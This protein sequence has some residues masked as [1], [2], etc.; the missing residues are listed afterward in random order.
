MIS[1]KTKALALIFLGSIFASLIINNN[2]NFN[3][4]EN[5][6]DLKI[7]DEYNLKNAFGDWDAP[8]KKSVGDNPINLF[9]G[10]A[11][12]DGYNDIVSTNFLSDDITIILWNPVSGN[13]KTQITKQTGDG[14]CSVFIEDA[15]NDGQND[16]VVSNAWSND[17]LILLWNGGSGNWDTSITKPVGRFPHSVFVG[18]ANNDGYNDIVTANQDD[19]DIS[20]YLW[21][22]GSNDWD[23]QIRRPVKPGG[24]FPPPIGFWPVEVS[25]NDANNDGYNDIITL[26]FWS[27]DVSIL[28]WNIDSSDW[29]P[30]IIKSVGKGPYGLFIGDAN[31]DGYNDIVTSNRDNNDISIYLWNVGS[32][33]WDPQ[34]RTSAG[35]DPER[36]FIGDANNDGYNDIV[37]TNFGKDYVSIILWNS[38][39]SNW[40]PRFTRKIGSNP[41]GV[42]IEDANNDG[43]NDIIATIVGEDKIS[44]LPWNAGS[45]DWDTLITKPVGRFPHSVFVGDANND[46]YNDI[47]TANQ[48]DDDVSIY[49]WNA[50]SND[51]DEQ[52]RRPVK[53][54]GGFPPPIGFWPVEV[55]VNDANN[56]GYNDIITLNFW[57][58][59]VSILLW[60][61]D[62]SDWDPPIIKSV[63]KGPYGLF[64]GDANNDGYN[65]IV[66]SNRDNNDISIYLWNVGSNEWD[67]QIRTSAGDDPERVFI[68]DANNDG[69]NDIVATNFGKDYVSIILWNS[70]SSNWDPRFTRKIGS[71]PMGVFIEDA[72]NDGYNDIIATIVGEDKISVLRWNA[73]YNDWDAPIKKPVGD[74]PLD[75]FV[76]DTNNDGYNDIV[77]ANFLTDDISILLWNPISGNWKTQIIKPTGDGCCNVFIEDANNDGYNEIITSNSWSND[78]SILLIEPYPVADF[79]TNQRITYEGDFITFAF[80]GFEGNA[81]AKYFWDFGDGVIS[82]DKNPVHKYSTKG[83]YTVKLLV[84]DTD[85]DTDVEIK[86]NYIEVREDL[87]PIADFVA[88]KTS[89]YEGENIIFTFIGF[90]GNSPAIFSWDFGDE[91]T[92]TEKNPTHQYI[93]SGIYDVSL[94]IIDIDDDVDIEIKTNFIYV[95]NTPVGYDVEVIDEETGINLIFDE[96][97]HSGITTIEKSDLEPELP[98]GFKVAGDYYNIS[99]DAL[100]TGEITLALPYDE[101]IIQGEEQNLKLYHWEEILG[102]TDITTSVDTENNVIYGKVYS[103]SI[104]IILEPMDTTEPVIIITYN[105]GDETDGNPGNWNVFAYD[106]ESDINLDTLQILIDGAFVG[107]EF[108]SYEVPNS[109]GEHIIYVEIKNNNPILPLLGSNWASTQIV[110]DDDEIPEILISYDGIR[111]DES[112][113]TWFVDAS[114]DSGISEIQVYRDGELIGNWLGEYLVPNTLGPHSI[115]IKVW[116]NDVDRGLEDREFSQDTH[117]VLIQDDDF[118]APVFTIE[119]INCISDENPGIWRIVAEDESGLFEIGLNIDGGE[120][121][122]T[123]ADF[124]TETVIEI[125]IPI[126]NELG[127]HSCKGYA[128]DADLDRGSIDQLETI[129]ESVYCYI[130]DDDTDPPIVSNLMITDTIYDISISFEVSDESGIKKV[131]INIDDEFTITYNDLSGVFLTFSVFNYWIMDFGTHSIEIEVWDADED[132]EDDSLSSKISGSFITSLEDMKQYVNWEIDGSIEEIKDSSDDFWRKKNDKAT[133]INKLKALKQLI[134]ENEF[135]EA[136]KKLLHDIKPKLTGLKTNENEEP[137]G[138]GVFKNSWVIND[139]LQE[140]FRLICNKILTDITILTQTISN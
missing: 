96:V 115:N 87:Q 121:T 24:G 119:A 80:T 101:T 14:C 72:N 111:T 40:D 88:D 90:E 13:W 77:S 84:I 137:W 97:I 75:L 136:Y 2:F 127:E 49:L 63:G 135:E 134:T 58:N 37:A 33:E 133:I 38:A 82:R 44:I 28:L 47:V 7:L 52:I 99:T 73:G 78:V 9:V 105:D 56:D 22:A 41:M 18:D 125:L 107:N 5:P 122:F 104:F 69:Y 25:V 61:I 70:A 19:D 113:G 79:I 48:D 93:S 64:I 95:K 3:P 86:R 130:N 89:I 92:S 117:E 34:I 12:N 30:P 35:D 71:N 21:N 51:W 94:L 128:I 20:I 129:H 66:T 45:P 17:I 109:L 55:S 46:G 103:F 57:S 100:F 85:G 59:D 98:T 16:I 112:P 67:P 43:Y 29:D 102:W 39:S 50:G 83:T 132:R 23:E 8:I 6:E 53:P 110:D 81:P 106:D 131:A 27:N 62:S 10:D 120:F 26:N 15:N 140:E 118:T 123:Q 60:N 74:N 32:N 91:T 54:G 76:R 36:V 126:N 1:N 31:N 42:F 114:D 116:D 65:D 4:R 11:N 68:G 124:G 138:D 108:G 139:D